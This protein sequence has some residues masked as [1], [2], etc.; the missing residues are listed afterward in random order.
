MSDWLYI[1]RGT[2]PLVVAFP[3]TGTDLANV[4]GEFASPWLAR[5][6]ADWWVDRLYAFARDLG[7]TTIRTAISRSVIDVN[8]DPSGAS[9]YPGQATTELCPT[10]TFDGEPLYSGSEPD[11]AEIARRRDNWFAPYHAAIES[12]LARL[13]AGH[14]AVV[15]YDAHSIRSHVPRLFDGE[16]PQFNIG[17]NGG[18]TCDKALSDAVT[19]ICAASGR[20]HVLDGRFRGGWTTRLYGRPADGIHAIQMELAIRG[21][22]PEPDVPSPS[23]WPPPFEPD[24][25][26]PLAASLSDILKACIAFA[27][28][29]TGKIDQ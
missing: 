15:L 27:Q 20:S 1:H 14:P 18:E 23:N 5:R 8:R 3:H 2:A 28:N 7:A 4:E 24:Y 6:D 10:T 21:Y 9:L 26:A 25:A 22:S 17:T 13:R 12:E 11:K 16:L 29:N 19:T